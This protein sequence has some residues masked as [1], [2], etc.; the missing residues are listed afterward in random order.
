MA[1]NDG[2]ALVTE[3]SSR[4]AEADGDVVE[5]LSPPPPQAER[6][7]TSEATRMADSFIVWKSPALK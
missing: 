4:L 2:P 3:G 6:R 7:T 1:G 5:P